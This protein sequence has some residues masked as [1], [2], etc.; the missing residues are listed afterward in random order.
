VKQTVTVFVSMDE[1]FVAVDGKHAYRWVPMVWPFR[2]DDNEARINI[3][4]Q[5]VE[6]EVPDNFSPVAGQVA[7]LRAQEQKELENY[8]NT[9]AKINDRLSKLLALTNGV[10]A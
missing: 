5:T 7:A 9:V 8:Q 2:M 3:G 10:D 6:V 4:E 1:R